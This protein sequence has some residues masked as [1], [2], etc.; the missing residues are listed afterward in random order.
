MGWCDCFAMPATLSAEK[1]EIGYKFIDYLLGAEFASQIAK[2]GNYATTSSIIR[3]ELSKEQQEAIFIDDM[4]VM[5]SFMWPVAPENYS[6]WLKI[7]NEVK[8]S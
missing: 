5:K 1:T 7:W 8:A 4:E 3:D 2:I 6:E